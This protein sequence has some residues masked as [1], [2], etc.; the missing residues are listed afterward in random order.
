MLFVELGK[1]N[2]LGKMLL[3]NNT[4]EVGMKGCLKK[5]NH[6]FTEKSTE[7]RMVG[8]SFSLHCIITLET[9]SDFVFCLYS[10]CIFSD[11][12]IAFAI[13]LTSS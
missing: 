10:L 12:V 5:K 2:K 6:R 7:L 9:L 8:T 1:K 4:I 11:K 3:N 13:S